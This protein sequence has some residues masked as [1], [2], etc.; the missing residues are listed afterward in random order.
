M[1]KRAAKI[2]FIIL[3]A[4]IAL[5]ACSSEK[6]IKVDVKASMDSK[7]AAQAKVMVDGAEVGTTD[8]DGVYTGTLKRN[9]GAEV[10][11]AVVMEATGYKAEPWKDSFVV[12]APAKGA[13]DTYTLEAKL[14]ATKYI[15]ISVKEEDKPVEGAAIKVGGKKAA[16][17]DATGQF[18]YE[19]GKMPAKGF[20]IEVKKQGYAS[21]RKTRKV[22]P[23]QVI[24]ISLH[25]E[26]L[27]TVKPRTEEYGRTKGM[28]GVP[29]RIDGKKVGKTNSKGS[30]TYVYK[31][32]PGKTVKVS[33]SIPGY[34]PS[35][36][37]GSVKLEG[38]H[39]ITRYFYPKSPKPIRA[40]IYGYASNTPDED[41][42][43]IL[44]RIE[45]AV[46]NNLFSYIVFDKVASDDLK[47][48][49]KKAKVDIEQM[50]T[51]GWKDTPLMG[52]IDA[53]ILGSIGKTEKGFAIETK[54]Y[55]YDGMLVL[56]LIKT[57]RGERDVKRVA[58]DVVNTFIKQFPFEGM[59]IA[60]EGGSYKINLGSSDYK[61]RRGAEFALMAPSKT[62]S[63]KIKGHTEV[64]T[65]RLKKVQKME[66]WGEVVEL[67]RGKK[68]APGYRV[69]RL[70]ASEEEKRA[71]KNSFV[72]QARGGVPPDLD[73]LGGVNVYLNDAWVG[74]TG[75]DGKTVVPVKLGKTYDI[76]L[77]RHGYQQVKEKV[78]AE[79]DRDQKEYLLEV[80]NALLRIDS[81]PS[82]AEVFIDGVSVGKSPITDGK[83]INFGFHTI[84]LSAGGDIRDW[85][86]VVEFNRKEVDL[87]GRNKIVMHKDYL[88]IAEQAIAGGDV[89]DAI[90]AYLKAGE[91][92]PDYSDARYRLAQLY[93]DEK[94]DYPAAAREFENVLSVPENEQLIYKQYAVTYTNLGHAYYE[95]GNSLLRDD[96]DAA[97]QHLAKAIKNLDIAKQNTRFLPTQHYD[98]AV[99]DTYYFSALSYHKLSLIT[100][101]E[102]H[103]DKA[104]LAWREYFDF[105]PPK[106]EEESSFMEIRSSAE[107]YWS[108]IRDIR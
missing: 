36:W 17:T 99:H 52:T 57:A 35:K 74:T 93:M 78:K 85:E 51:G 23:G 106:L 60:E 91:E 26:S 37:K 15:T 16:S 105:F 6:E 27:L 54:V 41:L 84:K 67:K 92:H 38:R 48:S 95:M 44:R 73:K 108:Q 64:G 65:L 61:L 3:L 62:S 32:E 71:A 12:K 2:S 55:K 18:V 20:K 39:S 21:W 107:K 10:S 69:V 28:A 82:G 25:K 5:F 83:Q 59:I 102:S 77:Y 19:Y 68:A 50:T 53:V 79:K 97:A 75:S 34:M 1:G 4:S 8:S 56:S 14:T 33:M 46:G 81:K 29:I 47:A 70:T 88:K 40:A 87:T 13:V 72:L 22:E 63:G 7:P 49:M 43:D 103:L 30:F 11:V 101:K 98:E 96:R 66:S 58:K 9:A 89:D 86:E 76:V 100:R 94:N 90:S 31:K 104:D 45:E 24:E 42:S 80:N